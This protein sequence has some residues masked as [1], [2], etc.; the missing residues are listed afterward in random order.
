MAHNGQPAIQNGTGI[1]F[2]CNGK[3]VD[4]APVEAWAV[5][6]GEMFI[7]VKCSNQEC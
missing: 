7:K 5:K 1:C 3:L 4:V 2:Y 6:S